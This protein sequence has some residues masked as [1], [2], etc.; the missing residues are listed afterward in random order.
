MLPNLKHNIMVFYTPK[1]ILIHTLEYLEHAIY[2]ANVKKHPVLGSHKIMTRGF[3][4]CGKLIF[5]SETPRQITI[6]FLLI[7][8]SGN[9]S[10][11]KKVGKNSIICIALENRQPNNAQSIT[12]LASNSIMK[13]LIQANG[14][15]S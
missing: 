2:D 15:Q 4:K 8:T 3:N 10:E 14:K 1:H 11:K 6:F 5:N 13:H 7:F 9:P 12:S